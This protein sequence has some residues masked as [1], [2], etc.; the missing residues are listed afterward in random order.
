[1][2]SFKLFLESV[3]TFRRDNP[4]GDWLKHKQEDAEASMDRT[5]GITGATTGYFNNTLW[6]PVSHLS[7]LRGARGEEA[8]RDSGPKQDR[9]SQQIG[10]PSNFNTKDN[11]IMVGINHNGEGVIPEGNHRLAYA[12]KHGIS[13]IHAEVRYYNGGEDHEGP[14]SPKS[15]LALHK[16]E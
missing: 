7:S 3:P 6:L 16:E 13:H 15:M 5:R 2:K 12:K 4:G 1:M 14:Y 11:P 8:Y 9:L 10:H